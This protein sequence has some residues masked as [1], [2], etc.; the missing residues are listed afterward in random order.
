MGEQDLIAE[1]AAANSGLVRWA[2]GHRNP[3]ASK[4]VVDAKDKRI[5]EL[6]AAATEAIRLYDVWDEIASIDSFDADE[7]GQCLVDAIQKLKETVGGAVFYTNAARLKHSANVA[8]KTRALLDAMESRCAVSDLP[9]E[10]W[11][12]EAALRYA[13]EEAQQ[14]A[15]EAPQP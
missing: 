2:Q 12:A 13:L 10:V 6:E 7:A 14:T 5:A 4:K 8:V 1:R 11:T 9:R 3:K 15:L